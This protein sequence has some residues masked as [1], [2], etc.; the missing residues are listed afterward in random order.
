M[1]DRAAALNLIEIALQ[2]SQADQ[3]E[4]VLTTG[5]HG[6]TRLANGGIHQH[7]ALADDSARVRAII[8]KRIGVATS[9]RL[10]AEDLRTL[11][12]RAVAIAR[13]SAP[14]PD[15]VSLPT[16]ESLTPIPQA[17]VVPE[18]FTPERRAREAQVIAET[19]HGNGLTASGHVATHRTTLAVGNSLGIRAFHEGH[20]ASVMAILSRG[21]ASGFA[22]WAGGS[23]DA[24][25]TGEVAG[26]ASSK[27]LAGEDPVSMPP[28]RYTVI[29]EPP[30]VAELLA[31]LGY[32]G[33]GA[34]A[35]QEDRSFVSGKLG[36]RVVGENITL[37]D[38]TYYHGMV[39]SPFDYEGVPKR[40]VPLLT[41]GV[42]ERVVYDAYT[43]RK[44]GTHS[45]GHALPAPNAQGPLPWNLVLHPGTY[46]R[47]EL[48]HG[49]T[50]GILVT[51]FH[52]VNIVH[53]KETI[54]TGMTRDG[55]F[56]IEH[57]SL[58]R[59]VMNLRFTQS[60]REAL[61]RVSGIERLLTLVNQEGIYCLVPSLR[62][63]DFTFSS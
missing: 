45:T 22:Q 17:P 21:N 62:I 59:G 63:E 53:P 3:T 16:P 1:Q 2:H 8:G 27:C 7:T 61:E 56:L 57:G 9:N 60:I 19:A 24:A 51:R 23:L 5:E 40:V 28:G 37:H 20:E 47:E 34:L 31:M 44:G 32:I 30:A 18:A 36:T 58:T 46:S 15:F 33:L 38:D 49:V 13:I 10:G 42:A 41:H 54:L 55:T 43:A 14:D 35:Y 6:L 4:V 52:Y 48:I 26:R 11:V 12:E 29:L 25:P 50:R 39:P